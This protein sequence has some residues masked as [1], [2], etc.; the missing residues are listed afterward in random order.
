MYLT[1]ELRGWASTLLP[2]ALSEYKDKIRC[3]RFFCRACVFFPLHRLV[4]EAKWVC[5]T[6]LGWWSKGGSYGLLCCAASMPCLIRDRSGQMQQALCYLTT[7]GLICAIPQFTLLQP[8]PS[9]ACQFAQT[10]SKYWWYWLCGQHWLAKGW[11]FKMHTW[12]LPNWQHFLPIAAVRSLM[13]LVMTRLTTVWSGSFIKHSE[14]FCSSCQMC[15][16]VE[17]ITCLRAVFILSHT[18]WIITYSSFVQRYSCIMQMLIVM[19]LVPQT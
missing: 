1:S 3:D 18:D 7:S 11:H 15:S 6:C 13:H 8:H 19:D 14:G 17:I 10:A 9:P 12:C 16:H 2:V 4:V 5:V